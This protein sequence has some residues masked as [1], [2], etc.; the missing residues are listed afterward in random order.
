VDDVF[1]TDAE[2][3]TVAV[4]PA[5][6]EFTG[7]RD[8]LTVAVD[9]LLEDGEP[10]IVRELYTVFDCLE[11]IVPEGEGGGDNDARAEPLTMADLE[12]VV[13]YVI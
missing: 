5:V 2:P 11:D 9:V 8:I 7:V 13:E 4:F 6:L 12:G 3:L 10:V 1:D